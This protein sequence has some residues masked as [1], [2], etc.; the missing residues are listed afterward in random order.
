[1]KCFRCIRRIIFNSIV[2]P[3]VNE[4]GEKEIDSITTSQ[5]LQIAGRAGRFGSSFKQGEVTA[6]HRD[7]LVRL[8]EI[9][10]EAVPPVRVRA[11]VPGYTA[12]PWAALWYSDPKLFCLLSVGNLVIKLGCVVPE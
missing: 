6:M 11:S 5:A 1:M 7:D 10:G 2:K 12:V 8:R 9:L 3:T 4:K